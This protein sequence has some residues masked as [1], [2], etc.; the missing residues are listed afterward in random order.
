MQ[1]TNSRVFKAACKGDMKLSLPLMPATA[2]VL[3]R[4]AWGGG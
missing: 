4:M 3:A 1:A 2:C